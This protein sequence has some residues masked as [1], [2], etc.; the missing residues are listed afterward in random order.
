MDTA[1][2]WSGIPLTISA[3]NMGCSICRQFLHVSSGVPLC[4]H[5]GIDQEEM[6]V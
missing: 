6:L 1:V 4:G 2:V 5:V 3:G